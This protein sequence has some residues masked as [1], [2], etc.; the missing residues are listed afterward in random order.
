[1]DSVLAEVDA[2]GDLAVREAVG[3]QSQNLLL[4][5]VELGSRLGRTAGAQPEAA[6]DDVMII[7][8]NKHNADIWRFST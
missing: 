3:H 1:L 7:R 4:A 8:G 2:A 6:D 5:D